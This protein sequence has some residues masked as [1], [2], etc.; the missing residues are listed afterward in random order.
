M[1]KHQRCAHKERDR[2]R[3]RAETDKTHRETETQRE[4][5]TD[6]QTD[7]QRILTQKCSSKPC[8]FYKTAHTLVHHTTH[9][10]ADF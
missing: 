5:L 2:E 1:Q 9:A 7:R 3:E 10:P 6:S 4:R 8:I